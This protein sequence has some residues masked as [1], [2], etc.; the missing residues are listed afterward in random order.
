MTRGSRDKMKMSEIH[1]VCKTSKK[2]TL[3]YFNNLGA[4]AGQKDRIKEDW[5]EEA[6]TIKQSVLLR[7]TQTWNFC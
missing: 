1:Q 7:T 5:G 6:V 2:F 4:L 3:E